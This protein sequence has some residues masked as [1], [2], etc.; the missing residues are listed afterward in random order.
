[1][2]LFDRILFEICWI[3]KNCHIIWG[4]K[5]VEICDENDPMNENYTQMKGSEQKSLKKTLRV[6][7]SKLRTFTIMKKQP[8]LCSLDPFNHN[9]FLD[10]HT[11]SSSNMDLLVKI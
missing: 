1:M 7:V 10:T 11:H 8:I 6:K 9:C 2:V 4:F 5:F 3:G